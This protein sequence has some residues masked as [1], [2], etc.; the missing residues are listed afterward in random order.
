MLLNLKINKQDQIPLYIQ[1]YEEIKKSIIGQKLEPAM[2]LPSVRR[3]STDL[4]LSKTTV[5][6]A[7]QQLV[8][9]GYIDAR[10]RS[11]YYVNPIEVQAVGKEEVPPWQKKKKDSQEGPQFDFW[12][13]NVPIDS[14]D[15]SL[16]R[17]Y[18]NKVLSAE[19]ERFLAFGS[20]QGEWDLREAI[21]R[22]VR[23][24]RGVICSPDQIVIGAGVQSLLGILS[25]LIREDFT[26]IGFEDPGFQ[27]GRHIFRHHGLQVLPVALEDD[28]I[29]LNSLLRKKTKLVYVSPSNQ[30]PM[31]AVMPAHKRTRLLNWAHEQEGLIIE[32]DYDS[33]LRYFGRPIPSLQ[34]MDEGS[35]VIYL[36]SFSKILSPSFR[37]SYM[38]LPPS[39]MG[40]YQAMG[41]NYSQTA[42][43]VE[44]AA[45]ALFIT[46]GQLE[47]HLRRIRKV[48]AK[49]NQILME[50]IENLMGKKVG[51]VGG[52][53]GLHI[54]LELK[55]SLTT[56]EVVARAKKVGVRV[57]PL[58]NYTLHSK[59]SPN[60]LVV[61]G[62]GGIPVE[63]IEPGIRLLHQAWF[64]FGK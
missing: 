12:N 31:G 41:H 36:G 7:Y 18:L 8:V 27:Q 32:D 39:L 6:G 52:E 56:E 5:E 23:R 34:G 40:K 60:P 26:T 38:I 62:Y 15:F 35:R 47:K 1:L 33:E 3:L 25:A 22:Y 54:L 20:P 37:I 42:S 24:S 44:Q 2:K 64:S 55:T 45:L 49:K 21:T 46:E 30:F 14:F 51:V 59:P 50:A 4:G 43:P 61:L 16:W 10:P 19:S 17:R 48:Y 28:G 53:T 58:S 29:S 63:D 9:E 13:D 57:N 11:G